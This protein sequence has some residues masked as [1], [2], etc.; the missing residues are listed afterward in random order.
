MSK[1]L[2]N[3]AT[4]MLRVAPFN[5]EMAA[6]YAAAFAD[7]EK[8]SVFYNHFNRGVAATEFSTT[9]DGTVINAAQ[10]GANGVHNIGTRTSTATD[11]DQVNFST[12]QEAWK[13]ASGK[14]LFLDAGIK[15]T[16]A[17]TNSA[18]LFVGL[19]DDVA[20]D[21]ILD[22]G[23]G[24]KTT[25]DGAGL[26][27]V[28]G[29]TVWQAIGSTGSD[30]AINTSAGSF[31]SGSWQRLAFFFDPGNG[32]DGYIYP[33]VNGV[34]QTRVLLEGLASQDECHAVFGVKTGT[35]A[36]QIIQLD[37]LTIVQVR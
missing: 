29:G 5:S 10:D 36:Q 14:P 30:Q 18:N 32:T 15:C 24:M 27:K 8:F 22:D 7:P 4:Q 20:A 28:D 11:N 25:F 9:G 3:V 16:E 35:G 26:F 19:S 12:V 23:A 1:K 2:E 31:T 17:A 13:M 21:L 33:F 37:W 6:V 34:E